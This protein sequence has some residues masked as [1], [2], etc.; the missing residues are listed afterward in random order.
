MKTA[1]QKHPLREQVR[2]RQQRRRR[3]L[4]SAALIALLLWLLSQ[5]DCQCEPEPAPPEPER[6]VV[7]APPAPPPT[8]PPPKPKLA[9]GKVKL[10]PRP[11]LEVPVRPE[12]PWLADFRL[13]VAA[14]SRTLAQCFT[15]AE[16][17]GALRWSALVHA[18][19]GRVSESE[20]DAMFR[21]TSLTTT[22]EA[23]VIRG[24]TAGRYTLNEPDKDAPARRVS[25]IFEF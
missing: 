8:K 19:S 7:V 5:L 23:C 20:V 24:L 11:P 25:L 10:S 14:R 22:Q 18:P 16:R 15:G 6:A 12:P 13:Q 9:T 17:P 21:G 3:R 4:L 1:Q 2:R